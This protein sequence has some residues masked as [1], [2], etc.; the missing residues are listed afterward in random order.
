[1]YHCLAG[2]SY[3]SVCARI[4]LPLIVTAHPFFARIKMCSKNTPFGVWF[5]QT[6]QRALGG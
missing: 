5:E 6:K 4:A 1:M 2:V 3:C